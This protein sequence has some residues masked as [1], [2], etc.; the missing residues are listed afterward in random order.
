MLLGRLYLQHGTFLDYY[1]GAHAPS[2]SAALRAQL[3]L[4]APSSSSSTAAAPSL[5]QNA[6]HRDKIPAEHRALFPQFCVAPGL[7]PMFLVHGTADTAVL[8]V[9]S[10]NFHR[11]LQ[12]AGVA[13]TLEIVDGKEHSFDYEPSAEAEFGAPGGLF[14]R[15]MGFLQ[16]ML[17]RCVR[18]R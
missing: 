14:D 9:E 12:D 2:L 4:D 17:L 3:T 13:S 15:A 8:L 18:A 1:T 16:E 7:P 11:L 5:P 6:E 10:Q